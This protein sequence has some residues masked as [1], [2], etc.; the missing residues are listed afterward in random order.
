MCQAL[1]HPRWQTLSLGSGM[2]SRYWRPL[3]LQ[4]WGRR[5][6]AFSQGLMLWD[7]P[8]PYSSVSGDPTR[9][10]GKVLPPGCHCC[11]IAKLQPR[12][13]AAGSRGRVP[14]HSQ[15]TSFPWAA[16]TPSQATV[17]GEE[18]QQ[19]YR[20]HSSGAGLVCSRA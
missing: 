7:A 4:N 20:C 9:A 15:G 10:L 13:A 1:G 18:A 8:A 19:W 17:A 6:A 16:S 14:A 5:A 11:R 3:S 12:G 2:C